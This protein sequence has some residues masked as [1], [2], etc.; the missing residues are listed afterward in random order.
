MSKACEQLHRIL[1][2]GEK[3]EFP[4]KLPI[5]NGIYIFYDKNEQGHCGDRIVRIGTHKKDNNLRTRMRQHFGGN[6]KSSVFRKHIGRALLHKDNHEAEIENKISEYL[7]NNFYFRLLE[8]DSK[9]KRLLLEQRLIGTVSKCEDCKP[10]ESWLGNSS[11]TKEIRESG[12]WLVEELYKD[13]LSE[14]D[15]DEIKNCLVKGK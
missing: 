4:F 10:S 7:K 6:K 14:S 2:D 1:L 9:E 13:E 12:L 15:L 11:P 5:D 8:V 3:F